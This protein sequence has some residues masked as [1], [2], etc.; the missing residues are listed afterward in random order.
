VTEGNHTPPR[1]TARFDANGRLLREWFGARP[2]GLS[3]RPEPNDPRR[4]WF[5]ANADKPAL[6]RCEVD[7][8]SQRRASL[9]VVLIQKATV[10][11]VSCRRGSSSVVSKERGDG[12]PAREGIFREHVLVALDPAPHPLFARQWTEDTFNT[13]RGRTAAP[14]GRQQVQVICQ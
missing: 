9:A 5:M 3:F 4:V 12:G 10:S 6:G 8:A 7:L 2:C 14:L 1:R 11:S 13:T